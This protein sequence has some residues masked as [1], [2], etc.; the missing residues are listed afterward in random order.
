MKIE[1]KDYP[2]VFSCMQVD[3]ID[4][5]GV[6]IL[7]GD[8]KNYRKYIEKINYSAC[9]YQGVRSAKYWPMNIG[10]LKNLDLKIWKYVMSNFLIIERQS[11]HLFLERLYR[12]SQTSIKVPYVLQAMGNKVISKNVSD[13][14]KFFRGIALYAEHRIV[15]ENTRYESDIS[16]G[17][18]SERNKLIVGKSEACPAP[19]N[20]INTVEAQLVTFLNHDST[21]NTITSNVSLSTDLIESALKTSML[22]K[23]FHLATAYFFAK[24]LC[25]FPDLDKDHHIPRTPYIQSVIDAAKNNTTSTLFTGFSRLL[26]ASSNNAP[27]WNIIVEKIK[28]IEGDTSNDIAELKGK[29]FEV[30]WH[31]NNALKE[32]IYSNFTHIDKNDLTIIISKMLNVRI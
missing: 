20:L 19:M 29:Y 5:L 24:C 30:V 32:T 7:E 18:Y 1:I 16:M 26:M 9:K 27:Y 14:F 31:I 15:F 17:L 12:L 25:V 13:T 4:E 21:N 6:P 22:H 28:L 10:A 2:V 23:S 3:V 11:K 8:T